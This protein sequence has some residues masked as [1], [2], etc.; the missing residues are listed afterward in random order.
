MTRHLR[1]RRHNY[2]INKKFQVEFITKFCSLVII[3]AILSG[4][5]IYLLSRSTVTTTFENSRL[6]IRSTADFIL[7]TVLLSSSIV[8]VFIGLMTIGL[9]LLTSHKIVGPLYRI[10][11]DIDEVASG[12]LTKHFKVRDKDE[13]K[14][15][16]ESLDKM[17]MSIK[18]SIG[19]VKSTLA[20]LDTAVTAYSKNENE[21]TLT[22]L[23]SKVKDLK[24]VLSKFN[25]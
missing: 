18:D 13:I 25:T 15:L 8:I 23:R 21:N 19:D 1:N 14:K 10:E 24:A 6:M 20:E 4:A 7:P 3:G 2:F 12:N 16:A 11:R 9:T 5:I 22:G 17:T